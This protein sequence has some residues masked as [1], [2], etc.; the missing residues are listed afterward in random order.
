[1][2][3][4][5]L[6]AALQASY[7]TT[8]GLLAG[9]GALSRTLG[10]KLSD[11]T[12]AG[13]A[14]GIFT[15]DTGIAAGEVDSYFLSAGL[16]DLYG[17]QNE[18]V[19]I[20]S[21]L[22]EAD[23]ANT[24]PL[25]I[26]GGSWA[27]W[28]ADASCAELIYPGDSALRFTASANGW[29]VDPAAD[30]LRITCAADALYKLTLVGVSSKLSAPAAALHPAIVG[31]PRVGAVVSCTDGDWS[32]APVFAYQWRRGGSPIANAKDATYSPVAADLGKA[33][34]RTSFAANIAGT[35]EATTAAVQV[36]AGE[37]GGG[38]VLDFSDP[39]NAAF[40]GH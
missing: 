22:I 31:I 37:A 23:L 15:A 36:Q 4:F 39:A 19:G 8:K 1:M 5:S 33:L 2:L 12:A 14:D 17:D 24:A 32:G 16:R 26:G 34:S 6:T 13:Q 35:T 9:A 30:E 40:A 3:T 21:V 25:K 27:G 28:F 20:K 10:L 38:V 7:T 11:G 29:A 18:F